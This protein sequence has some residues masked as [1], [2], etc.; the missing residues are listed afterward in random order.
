MKVIEHGQLLDE[1]TMR[2]LAEKG[3]FLSIQALDPAPPTAPAF[4]R[5]DAADPRRY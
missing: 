4:T 2:L 3:I 1:A 5:G